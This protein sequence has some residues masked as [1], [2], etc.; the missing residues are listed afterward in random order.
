VTFSKE[1]YTQHRKEIAMSKG[2]APP[3]SVPSASAPSSAS[4]FAP[5]SAPF[6]PFAPFA[7]TKNELCVGG[8]EV[9][10]E[11]EKACKD[12]DEEVTIPLTPVNHDEEC[13]CTICLMEI[14]AGAQVQPHKTHSLYTIMC[15][16][17][18]PSML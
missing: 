14:E 11:E 17:P 15:I 4:A 13:E 5:S 12:M 3:S 7:L 1:F 9:G 10:G 18:T 2:D 16:K 6:A 8:A